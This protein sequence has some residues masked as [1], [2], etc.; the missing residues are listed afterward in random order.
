M[1]STSI[2]VTCPEGTDFYTW[3]DVSGG[4]V[5][6]G[7]FILN[8]DVSNVGF[9]ATDKWGNGVVTG[10]SGQF[11]AISL[12]AETGLPADFDYTALAA[13]WVFAMSVVVA[14]YVI[15]KGMGTLIAMFKS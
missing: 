10:M 8:S 1:S 6:S 12:Q 13:V 7:S 11:N 3:D 5:S 2:Y 9:C 15:A 14:S 4:Y